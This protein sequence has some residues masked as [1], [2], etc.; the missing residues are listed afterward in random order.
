MLRITTWRMNGT[1]QANV[2]MQAAF[3]TINDMCTALEKIPAAGQVRWFIGPQG[4]VTVGEPQNYAVADAILKSPAAQ[5]AV[6]KVLALGYAIVD[7]QFLL[8]SSQVLPFAPPSQ[9]VPA[10]LSRN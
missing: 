9:A 3:Q 4:V 5:A 7:D 6:A 1:P 10:G 2:T 8:E